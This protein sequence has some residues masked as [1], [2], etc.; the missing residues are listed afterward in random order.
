MMRMNKYVK[1]TLSACV[2]N[3]RVSFIT[4]SAKLWRNV[5]SNP[6]KIRMINEFSESSEKIKLETML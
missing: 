2:M 5:K 6:F 4:L 1:V 3:F